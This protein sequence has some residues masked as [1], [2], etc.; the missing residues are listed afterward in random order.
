MKYGVQSTDS[1][2]HCDV[3][4]VESTLVCSPFD[5]YLYVLVVLVVDE[6]GDIIIDLIKEF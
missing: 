3:S 1:G 5:C 4:S 2:H 6:N